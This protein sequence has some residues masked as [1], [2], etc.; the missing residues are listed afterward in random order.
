MEIALVKITDHI[1]GPCC[2]FWR[3]ALKD[4]RHNALICNTE[5]ERKQRDEMIKKTSN[6]QE[7]KKERKI[8]RK[9]ANKSTH[10]GWEI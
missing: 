5:G 4:Y 8:Q 2:N 6:S 3:S 7:S 10:L 1:K 9:W